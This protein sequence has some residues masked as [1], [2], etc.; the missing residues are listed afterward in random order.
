MLVRKGRITLDESVAQYVRRL[1]GASGVT[2]ATMSPAIA[3]ASTLLP[4]ILHNDPADRIL[5]ATAAEY[6][7]DFATRDRAIQAYAHETNHIHCIPC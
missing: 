4:G 6:G 2:V 3:V 5:I 7:A 1:F